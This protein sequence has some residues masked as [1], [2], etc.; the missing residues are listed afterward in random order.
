MKVVPL[1]ELHRLVNSFRQN[2]QR[3]SNRALIEM[4][5]TENDILATGFMAE[6]GTYELA[7]RSIET[8]ISEWSVDIQPFTPTSP[9][10]EELP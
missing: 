4:Q 7:A 3:A 6:S 9:K 5:T 8:L 10:P 1:S 2:S